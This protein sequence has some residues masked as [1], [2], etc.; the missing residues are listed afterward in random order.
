MS[1]KRKK[2]E[3][4]TIVDDFMFGKVMRNPEYCKRLL[5]IILDVRIRRLEYIEEEAT[6]NPSYRGK[7]IRLD[8]YVENGENS[9]YDVEMQTEAVDSIPKRCRYYQAVIDISLIEKG[10]N[11]KALRKSYV[12]FICTFDLFHKGLPIYH[13]ENRC[14]ENPEIELGDASEKI[15]LNTKA[16]LSGVS[17]ELRCLLEYFENQIPQDAFTREL[18]EA[19]MEVR[20]HRAFKLEYMSAWAREQDLREEGREEGREE[21]IGVLIATCRES[22]Q[23]CEATAGI[24]K[25]K[26]SLSEEAVHRA[27]ERYW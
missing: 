26:L 19:V 12:I 17:G 5:E 3:E 21:V 10:D 23:T 18:E 9:V 27:M 8:I 15:F 25:E 13:F 22:G 7:G 4:L 2:Y 11:Y 24:L 16:N 6:K 1:K 20:D 14:R